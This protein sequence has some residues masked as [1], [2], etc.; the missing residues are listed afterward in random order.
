MTSCS[1]KA[2]TTYSLVQPTEI[3]W[4]SPSFLHLLVWLL[5]S[6]DPSF[7][8]LASLLGFICFQPN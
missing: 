3:F 2:I 8:D 5:A 7:Q 4:L 6:M 1:A